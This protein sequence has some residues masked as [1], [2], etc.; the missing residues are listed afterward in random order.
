[1]GGDE[2]EIALQRAIL[3]LPHDRRK[4]TVKK[5]RL[6]TKGFR[7]QYTWIKTSKEW[8]FYDFDKERP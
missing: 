4:G 1:M 5:W 2:R 3:D 8:S 7:R 6:M